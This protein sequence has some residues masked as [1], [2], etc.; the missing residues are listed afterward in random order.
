MWRRKQHGLLA[1]KLNHMRRPVDRSKIR[2]RICLQVAEETSQ[3]HRTDNVLLNEAVDRLSG[4]GW[5]W[6]CIHTLVLLV[7]NANER[8]QDLQEIKCMQQPV[9]A[10]HGFKCS[11]THQF[12]MS[13][14]TRNEKRP[15]YLAA[16]ALRLLAASLDSGRP[17]SKWH[18]ASAEQRR[19][20]FSAN[21]ITL[22]PNGNPRTR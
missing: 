13:S 21:R 7:V 16:T 6:G 8:Q 19:R 14:I 12:A 3:R 5:S 11:N 17:C 15:W 10:E 18:V 20:T 1:A 2:R 4:Q 22:V 9:V